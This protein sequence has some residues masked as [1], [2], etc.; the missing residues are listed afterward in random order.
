MPIITISREMGT[1]AF[2]IVQDVAKKLKFRLIDGGYLLDV[3][4]RYGLSRQIVERIDEHPPSYHTAEDRLNASYLKTIEIMILDAAKEG[5]VIIY[6]RGGQD[7]LAGIRN[8]LRIRFIAP[9]EHRVET[10]A[11]RE[12]IDPEFARE[13][14][15]RND[16]QRGGFIHFYFDR[17]WNDPLGYDLIFNTQHM[18]PSAIVE[19][20][21]TAARDPKLKDRVEGVSIIEERILKLKVEAAIL[22]QRKISCYSLVVEVDAATVTLSGRISSEEERSLILRTVRKIEGISDIVD[23]MKVENLKPYREPVF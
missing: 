13:L 14:I 3:A 21:V 17:D 4:P 9:F 2:R 23:V 18:T 16:H 15:R 22:K 8:V 20:I 11:E 1:G 10:I 5:N 12:W 19:I 6:G 7:L